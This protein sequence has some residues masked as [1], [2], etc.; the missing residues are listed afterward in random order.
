MAIE[1]S[2]FS[3]E[4]EIDN[5]RSK[6]Y[7]ESDIKISG[8]NATQLTTSQNNATPVF[9]Y[10]QNENNFYRISRSW[11]AT[12]EI[13]QKCQDIFDKALSGFEFIET[14]SLEEEVSPSEQACLDAGGE[15]GEML[16]CK[17]NNDFPNMCLIGSC[18]CSPADSHMVKICNCGYGKCFNGSTC[19]SQ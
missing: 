14:E 15:V 5:L 17:S 1:A 9:I 19:V 18:G 2:A 7:T 4:S 13:D 6:E 12:A 11:G 16:C 8:V 3:F 10:F